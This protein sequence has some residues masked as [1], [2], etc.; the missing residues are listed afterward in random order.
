MIERADIKGSK[1]DVTMNAWPPQASYPCGKF[2]DTSC[3]KPQ[4][5]EGL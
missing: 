1:S 3:L 5:S 4:R 2:C